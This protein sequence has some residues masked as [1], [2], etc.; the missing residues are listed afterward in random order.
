MMYWVRRVRK[1]I[2]KGWWLVGRVLVV[3]KLVSAAFPPKFLHWR[4]GLNLLLNLDFIVAKARSE[5]NLPTLKQYTI[6]VITSD[7]PLATPADNGQGNVQEPA[8]LN[9][10]LDTEKLKILKMGSSYIRAW[11]AKREENGTD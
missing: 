1:R 4:S 5:R 3:G 11:I 6:D 9:T 7:S 2:F 10:E 8:L